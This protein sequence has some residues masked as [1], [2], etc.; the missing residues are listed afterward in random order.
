MLRRP[1]QAAEVQLR[2]ERPLAHVVHDAD[3]DDSDGVVVVVSR[4]SWWAGWLRHSAPTTVVGLLGIAVIVWIDLAHGRNPLPLAVLGLGTALVWANVGVR[5]RRRVDDAWLAV[6]HL[7]RVLSV[8]GA[9]DILTTWSPATRWIERYRA[10]MV[11]LG[12][13]GLGLEVDREVRWLRELGVRLVVCCTAGGYVRD[14]TFVGPDGRRVTL[15]ATGRLAT[16][17]GSEPLPNAA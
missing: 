6:N 15:F 13:S 3:L 10:Q 8:R 12:G 5:R 14:C 2:H 1:I 11:V 7:E 4:L 16:L 17:A 9:A